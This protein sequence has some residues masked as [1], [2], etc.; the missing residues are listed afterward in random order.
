MIKLPKK[1]LDIGVD[2]VL[3]LMGQLKKVKG[4]VSIIRKGL[5]D[6]N[7]AKINRR[8]QSLFVFRK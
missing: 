1:I 3:N 2:E 7:L 6:D 5:A 4:P 8:D